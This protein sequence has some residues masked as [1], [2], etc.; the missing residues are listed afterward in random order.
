MQITQQRWEYDLTTDSEKFMQQTTTPLSE[1]D[2]S[3]PIC[4]YRTHCCSP[5]YTSIIHCLYLVQSLCW[6]RGI[7]V[8]RR[9]LASELSLSCARPAVD[10]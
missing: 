1:A 4:N 3:R 8:E 7:V 9:S 6:W 10:G 5:R 2:S